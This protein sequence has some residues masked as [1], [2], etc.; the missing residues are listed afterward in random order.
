MTLPNAIK[1]IT[2]FPA[3][4]TGL[5]KRGIIK[6]GNIADITILDKNDYKIRDVILAGRSA[7]GVPIRHEAQ[8]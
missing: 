5:K 1:K 3:D 4:Y 2:S 8:K 6:E 7:T